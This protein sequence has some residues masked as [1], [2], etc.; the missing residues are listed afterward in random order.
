MRLPAD[1]MGED[2][3]QTAA[4]E[5]AQRANQDN[6]VASFVDNR[7]EAVAQRQMRRFIDASPRVQSVTQLQANGQVV[8]REPLMLADR[9]WDQVE[10]LKATF[11]TAHI[12]GGGL[13]KIPKEDEVWRLALAAK[14]PKPIGPPAPTPKHLDRARSRR[15]A[16]KRRARASK[17]GNEHA[18]R[19]ALNT[20]FNT[21]S[22]LQGKQAE[23]LIELTRQLWT[24]NGQLDRLIN[25]VGPKQHELALKDWG[26]KKQRYRAIERKINADKDGLKA[27]IAQLQ[28]PENPN[29]PTLQ[30]RQANNRLARLTSMTKGTIKGV[31]QDLSLLRGAVAWMSGKLGVSAEAEKAVV[32]YPNVYVHK[33]VVGC[34]HYHNMPFGEMNALTATGTHGKDPNAKPVHKKLAGGYAI[35]F[36]YKGGKAYVTDCGPKAPNTEEYNWKRASVSYDS[37]API[38]DTKNYIQE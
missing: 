38:G 17:D 8:Q 31:K 14:V 3:Q 4:H 13:S 30:L 33:K 22:D 20:R 1:K 35:T 12:V 2:H 21:L 28:T 18:E 6:P 26:E 37:T 36:V 9:P 27:A 7:S 5:V 11:G 15:K 16:Q 34:P 24:E 19:R 10:R 32:H 25:E 29:V 23:T